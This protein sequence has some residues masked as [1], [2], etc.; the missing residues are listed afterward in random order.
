[1]AGHLQRVGVCRSRSG[2]ASRVDS[3]S[4]RIAS[5][6]ASGG[7]ITY[8]RLVSWPPG[9]EEGGRVWWGSDNSR[10][11]IGRGQRFVEGVCDARRVAGLENK[12]PASLESN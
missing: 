7:D 6:G 9:A 1:M 2:E 8:V 4:C 10:L 5:G 3:L 11:E 12:M